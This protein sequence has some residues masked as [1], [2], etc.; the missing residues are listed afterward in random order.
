MHRIYLDH[1]ATTPLLPEA[2]RAMEA[3]WGSDL[4]NPSSLHTEGRRARR[5]VED[6]REE[7]AGLLGA[8]PGEVI[9]TAGATEANN[10]ALAWR[11]AGS[12]GR[13][14]RLAVSAIEH[15]SVLA[16]AERWRAAGGE[17]STLSVDREACL[18]MN[19]LE[20]V[21]EA[22]VDLVAVM[23]ASNEVGTLQ[24]W[25]AI[26]K[27]CAG[28]GAWLHV[29]AVQV[30]GK[31]PFTVEIFAPGTTVSISGH[32]FGGP[33]GV[34]ALW[35][36]KETRLAPVI[37]GGQ[38]ERGRRAGTENVAAISG[39]G[40]ACRATTVNGSRWA[41]ARRKGES[42]LLDE[43]RRRLG[44]LHV[45]GPDAASRVPGLFSVR[46]EGVLGE[47]LLFALD[48]EGVAVSLGSACSSGAA[49]PSH[50]LSAMGIS[51]VENLESLRVSLGRDHTVEELHEAAR[52]IAEVSAR[53]RK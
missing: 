43:L 8:E 20:L 42:I 14:P 4:G 32:K 7:V 25:A 10:L 48:L 5:V 34:G 39:F 13:P 17:V 30:V 44:P 47:A 16:C 24:D 18:D 46:F 53:C 33:R 27:C 31:L 35:V 51:K 12:S 29:D 15:P 9:F 6:A 26:S 38:Q 28:H 41:D 37:V 45:H 1:A 21:L 23:A 49:Q 2:L 50:V 11:P 22:G 19:Q 52:I 40:A 3:C 36:E